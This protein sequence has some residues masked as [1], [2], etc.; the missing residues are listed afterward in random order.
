MRANFYYQ[1]PTTKTMELGTSL[2]GQWLRLYLLIQGYR[3]NPGWGAKIPHASQPKNQKH[4]NRSNIVTNSK[5]TLK[6]VHVKKKKFLTKNNGT[7]F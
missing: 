3:F 1:D 5:K 4:K 2:E 6:T 7:D